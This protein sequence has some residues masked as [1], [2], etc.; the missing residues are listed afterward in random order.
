MKYIIVTSDSHGNTNALKNIA[1]RYPDAFCYLNL[2]DF[3]DSE[4]AISPFLSVKG[5]NDYLPIPLQRIIT[6]DNKRILMLHGHNTFLSL[7]FMQ[8]FTILIPDFY[9][10]YI[11]SLINFSN[12]Y[13]SYGLALL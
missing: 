4:E 13:Y 1:L 3:C 5:N 12:K 10:S 11:Q 2:G 7:I 6:I 9:N 8:T